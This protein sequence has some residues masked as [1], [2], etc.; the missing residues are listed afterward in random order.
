MI[1]CVESFFSDSKKALNCDSHFPSDYGPT[2]NMN[3]SIQVH[4][5]PREGKAT[6]MSRVVF[7]SFTSLTYS[8]YFQKAEVLA[9][10]C[11][12]NN[13]NIQ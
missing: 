11:Y 13:F 2:V 4:L 8:Y 6:K 1:D 7:F 10:I 3:N 12:S 5:H 9:A